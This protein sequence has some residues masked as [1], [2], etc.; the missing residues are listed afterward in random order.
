MEILITK[1]ELNK[2]INTVKG[3]IP[4]KTT[5][6]LLECILV[7]ASENITFMAN[8]LDLGIKSVAD[9]EIK[10]EG[11]IAINA[12]NLSEL[13]RKLPDGNVTIKTDNSN[14]TFKCGKFKAVVAGMGGDEYPDIQADNPNARIEIS[15]VSLKSIIKQ[16]IFAASDNDANKIMTGELFE[17]KGDRLSITALDGHRIARR[18][19]GLKHEYED[20]KVIIPAK[21]LGEVL[22][23]S[24]GNGD[25][26]ICLSS[27]HA[28]F[29]FDKA[30]VTTRLI[31]G[32]YFDIDR[33]LNMSF[34]TEVT[35]SRKDLYESI[36]RS[37]LAI[38]AADKRPIIVTVTDDSI[39]WVAKTNTD[40]L[41]DEINAIKKGSDVRI[42]FNPRLVM[43]V[44]NVI[45]DEN[46]TLSLISPNQPCVIKSDEYM[47]LV[48]PVNIGDAK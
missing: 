47:Y 37:T 22:K 48:L 14:V 2:A 45:E 29:E 1:D 40:E 11:K 7:R 42:G 35:A 12:K 13:A 38:T 28:V 25:M 19:I 41:E 8:S 9:G 5:M 23:A 36:D 27:N 21:A 43:D 44:L 3:A 4:G 10:E 31:E 17:V 24:S 39:K 33:M 18:M 32:Q 6:P 34:G 46:V 15:Q 26:M 16:T 30:I 20:T